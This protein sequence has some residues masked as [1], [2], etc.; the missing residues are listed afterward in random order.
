MSTQAAVVFQ[1]YENGVSLPRDCQK[2]DEGAR[3]MDSTRSCKHMWFLYVFRNVRVSKLQGLGELDE[4]GGS[5]FIIIFF[6]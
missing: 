2:L 6:V 1:N 5:F 4:M 3:K